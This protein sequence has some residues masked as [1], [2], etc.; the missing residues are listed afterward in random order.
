MECA[1]PRL[2][3]YSWHSGVPRYSNLKIL[4]FRRQ[5]NRSRAGHE[6]TIMEELRKQHHNLLIVCT[7]ISARLARVCEVTVNESRKAV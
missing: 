1:K 6:I 5:K 2:V 4:S 3:I 7:Y